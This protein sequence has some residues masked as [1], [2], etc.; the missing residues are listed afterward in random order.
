MLLKM[1]FLFLDLKTM[2]KE[3]SRRNG[4]NFK[5]H[6][7]EKYVTLCL[8]QKSKK[9]KIKTSIILSY[10]CTKKEVTCAN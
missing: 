9:S 8:Y 1:I 5:S 3:E 7:D 6:I 4:E 10:L 2:K